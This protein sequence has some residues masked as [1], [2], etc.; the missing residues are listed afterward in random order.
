MANSA[1]VYAPGR[2]EGHSM[3]LLLDTGSAVTLTHS[4][5][6]DRICRGNLAIEKASN[7]VISANGQ[8]LDVLGTCKCRIRRGGINAVDCVVVAA[9][10][11]SP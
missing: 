7:R 3:N 6:L 2:V 8:V 10:I 1:T 5:I 9:D 11:P 4:W